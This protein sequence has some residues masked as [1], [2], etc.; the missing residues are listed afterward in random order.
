MPEPFRKAE[1]GW[2]H[3]DKGEG[4]GY[5]ATSSSPRKREPSEA[6]KAAQRPSENASLKRSTRAHG[7]R[8]TLTAAPNSPG[9]SSRVRG[10]AKQESSI[11]KGLLERLEGPRD[12]TGNVQLYLTGRP[13]RALRMGAPLAGIGVGVKVGELCQLS[14]ISVYQCSYRRYSLLDCGCFCQLAFP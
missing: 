7:H 4:A 14:P 3:A 6:R 13:C 2:R 8:V 12:M 9:A 11:D 1:P 5:R 10:G